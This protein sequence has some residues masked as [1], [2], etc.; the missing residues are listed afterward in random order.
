MIGTK[1]KKKS[2]KGGIKI[3]VKILEG[4]KSKQLILI[5]TKSIF[6]PFLIL[7]LGQI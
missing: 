6:M 4:S 7:V 1:N 2:E 5:G 3:K